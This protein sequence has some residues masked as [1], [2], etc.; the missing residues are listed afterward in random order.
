[1]N[2][3]MFERVSHWDGERAEGETRACV[4]EGIDVQTK[5][6]LSVTCG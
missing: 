1:M 6:R 4:I 5:Q 2:N 3:C